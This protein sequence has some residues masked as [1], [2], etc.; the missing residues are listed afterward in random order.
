M[1][2]TP[3]QALQPGF[4]PRSHPPP[5]RPQAR[6]LSKFK[7]LPLTPCVNKFNEEIQVA[8]F[9]KCLAKAE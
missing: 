7:D 8:G 9:I 1:T 3:L 6:I 4:E 5:P 2:K